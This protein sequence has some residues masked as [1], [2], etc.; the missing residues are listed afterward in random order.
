LEN[1]ETYLK[2]VHQDELAGQGSRSQTLAVAAVLRDS[3]EAIF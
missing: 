3:G 1:S 2:R